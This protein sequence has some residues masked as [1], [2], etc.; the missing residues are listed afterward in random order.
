MNDVMTIRRR[1]LR[2]ERN[3]RK[4]KG[5]ERGTSE[6]GKEVSKGEI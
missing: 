1:L 4:E 2:N 3:E 5:K 6:R